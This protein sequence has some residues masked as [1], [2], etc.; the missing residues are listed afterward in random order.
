MDYKKIYKKIEKR[1]IVIAL[2]LLVFFISGQLAI[3]YQINL[4]KDMAN[5]INISGRQR[6]LSQKITKDALK[7]YENGDDKEYYINDLRASL[8]TFE[9]S[10][11]DLM[12]GNEEAGIVVKNS[13]VII[14][15]F[16]EISPYF[17]NILQSGNK[18]LD[19]LKQE[20][21]GNEEVFSEMKKISENEKVF[22]EKMN[23]IVFQYDYEAENNIINLERTESMVFYLIIIAVLII[24]VFIF[25]PATK[26]LRHAFVDISESNENIIKLIY[27]MKGA[28]FLVS[29]NGEMLLKNSDA[30]A[31]MSL[32]KEA[33]NNIEKSIKWLDLSIKDLIKKVLLG[34]D[35]D[36]IEVKVED[37]NKKILTMILSA[38]SGKYQQEDVVL[39]NAYDIT[40]QKKAEK[41][42]KNLADKDELTGLYNRH[43][44]DLV[45]NE[46]IERSNRYEFPVSA[47]ILD[48]DDFKKINDQ[49]GH[50]MGDSVLKEIARILLDNSRESDY[51]F[52]IGGEE[53]V[54]IMPHTNLQGAYSVA[55]K[56][57]KIIEKNS[58]PVVGQYT[59][60][61]GVA[62]RQLGENYFELYNRMDGA[63]YQAKEKGKNCVVKAFSEKN[64]KFHLEWK[65]AWESGEKKID[66]QHKQLFTLLKEIT[67]EKNQRRQAKSFI[68]NIE[69]LINCIDEHFTYE[70]GVLKDIAYGQYLE[71]KKIHDYLLGKVKN[72]KEKVIN[73]EIQCQE[74]IDF[75]FH[76]L[77]VGHLLKE[78]TK[79]FEDIKN[80]KLTK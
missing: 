51:S 15:M 54:I 44:L 6:M 11:N 38:I 59:V 8:T 70:E 63:L 69:Q 60:S 37:K 34:E 77:I 31:I 10:H 14:G 71:H 23:Q 68:N 67:D 66:A 35:V 4:G 27:A 75:M 78:D 49:W 61:F 29:E 79:F 25:I 56:I 52:R 3:Q 21:N 64:Y 13:D 33:N 18:I 17:N 12:N 80:K 9:T 28:L 58:H 76:D 36:R 32:D 19:L 41:M 43:F 24:T 5:V 26:T 7:I 53:F 55:E 45:I 62:E 57:R 39:I 22:L 40:A 48:I 50:P 46:E 16:N 65:E 2:L 74:I 72:L 42:L 30:E 73:G 1:Y 47:A 20:P